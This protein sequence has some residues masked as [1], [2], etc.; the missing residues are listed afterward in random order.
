M[1][2]ITIW[3]LHVLYLT[4]MIAIFRMLIRR[5]KLLNVHLFT[6][7]KIIKRQKLKSQLKISVH[8]LKIMFPSMES[9]RTVF[10]FCSQLE[11][12]ALVTMSAFTVFGSYW[13]TLWS[14]QS[15]Q[16]VPVLYFFKK[17]LNG[18]YHTTSEVRLLFSFV[19]V[20]CA[21]LLSMVSCLWLNQT[22]W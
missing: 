18:L 12:L 9:K 16:V 19:C 11:Y 5:M 3:E 10:I 14:C 7:H 6:E 17:K 1:Q 4:A 8:T 20:L 2:Q 15:N 22:F 13:T 21:G